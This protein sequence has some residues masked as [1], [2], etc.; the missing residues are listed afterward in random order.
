MFSKFAMSAFGP[1]A[2]HRLHHYSASV[3]PPLPQI[4]SPDQQPPNIVRLGSSLFLLLCVRVTTAVEGL[5]LRPQS[6]DMHGVIQR[7]WPGAV[8]GAVKSPQS[9]W[10]RGRRADARRHALPGPEQRCLSHQFSHN[11]LFVSACKRQCEHVDRVIEGN[12]SAC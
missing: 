12:T 8:E 7:R 2:P 1:R 6:V 10:D 5:V 4:Q 3:R 11:C 9:R